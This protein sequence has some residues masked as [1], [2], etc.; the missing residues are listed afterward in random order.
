[1]RIA[2]GYGDSRMPEQLLDSHNIHATPRSMRR[3]LG[4][5][6][7]CLAVA[8]P[9]DAARARERREGR[10]L[11]GPELV[12]A[13]IFNRRNRSDGISFELTER[14]FIQKLFRQRA[15][16]QTSPRNRSQPHSYHG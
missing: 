9:K 12:T 16:R 1:M 14:A 7:V 11:K 3:G 13:R 15:Q 4:V 10:R 2:H 5:L 6:F 8:I